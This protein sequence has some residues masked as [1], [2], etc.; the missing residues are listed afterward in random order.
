MTPHRIDY[1]DFFL[2]PLEASNIHSIL[3]DFLAI[4][5]D[6]NVVR[7]SGFQLVENKEE[8]YKLLLKYA[9]KNDFYI[10]L[11]YHKQS[12]R[13]IG[14]ISLTVDSYHHFASVGCFL[15]KDYWGRGIMAK[16]LKELLFYA[17]AEEGLH[18]VEAQVHELNYRSQL[19]FEK[20]GF[21]Y[22]GTL[23]QN[24]FVDGTFYDSKL[25][26]LLFD[27][28]MNLYGKIDF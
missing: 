5:S 4:Y 26:R 10:W 12:L 8:A 27:E 13:Y 3:E 16:S 2:M 6:E 28:Y 1:G 22:E 25:Y 23:K 17:F 20:F 15:R 9:S 14:D 11:I 7:Y 18:R 21:V 24:F 19:F